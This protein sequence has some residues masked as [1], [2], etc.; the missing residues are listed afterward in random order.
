VSLTRGLG[1]SDCASSLSPP[2]WRGSEL[3]GSSTRVD[4]AQQNPTRT[5][6][7][8]RR[9]S[10]ECRGQPY[11]IIVDPW[12]SGP[13]ILAARAR[14]SPSVEL[15][16]AP[17]TARCSSS[18]LLA[19]ARQSARCL[20]RARGCRGVHQFGGHGIVAGARVKLVVPPSGACTTACSPCCG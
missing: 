20:A 12:D 2:A 7:N 11:P 5:R 9:S 3:H 17:F 13:Y 15:S 16:V 19:T 10:R 8:R 14:P 18:P 4:S 1:R 6:R